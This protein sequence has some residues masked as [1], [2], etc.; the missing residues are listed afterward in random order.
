MNELELLI[1]LL[2]LVCFISGL[3]VGILIGDAVMWRPLDR[4]MQRGLSWQARYAVQA[5]PLMTFPTRPA[6]RP[7]IA[8]WLIALRQVLQSRRD[9]AVHH[10]R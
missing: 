8:I 2:K 7:S 4:K 9:R 1:L 3:L 10:D 5:G 6:F